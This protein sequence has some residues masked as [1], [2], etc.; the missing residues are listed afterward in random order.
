MALP[1]LALLPV[2]LSGLACADGS[3]PSGTVLEAPALQTPRTEVPIRQNDPATGC[4]FSPTHGYGF[5]VAFTW[6]A[7]PEAVHYHLLLHHLG[8]A[9]PVLDIQ[10]EDPSY[11]LLQCN[12][13]VID[14]NRFDWKW[15]VAGVSADDEEGAWAEQR[16]YEF[17][18]ITLPPEP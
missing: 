1:R 13:Y 6:T 4:S 16:T 10:V 11:L 2:F 8:S 5:Q 14:A 17:E 3:A 18:P 7:V 9:F 12:A 15:A